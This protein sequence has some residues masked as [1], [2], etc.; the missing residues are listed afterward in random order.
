MVVKSDSAR[1]T[2]TPSRPAIPRTTNGIIPLHVAAHPPGYA[3]LELRLR[4]R[5]GWIAIGRRPA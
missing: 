5:I 2:I 4:S 1:V 3:V